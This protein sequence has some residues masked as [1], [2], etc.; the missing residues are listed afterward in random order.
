L[1]LLLGT[2]LGTVISNLARRPR[3]I[4]VWGNGGS[5]SNGDGR[6]F[7]WGLAV[8][9]RPTFLGIHQ[10]G[11]P[12][13]ALRAQVRLKA[14][15]AVFHPVPWNNQPDGG[16]VTIEPW[17]AEPITLFY[18]YE[19]KKGFHILE[20]GNPV[21][22]FEGKE[23]KFVL[24]LQDRLERTMDFPMK[25]YFDD[26]DTRGGP[27]FLIKVAKPFVIRKRWIPAYWHVFL[28]KIGI[29]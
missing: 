23:L 11:D 9:N 10:D 26:S 7:Y 16:P 29:R 3:L 24:R 22:S 1:F 21:E 8:T 13:R 18:W 5:T 14:R 12:A 27:R 2:V 4:P 25:V 20:R 19:G 17:L 15:G 6:V 28:T